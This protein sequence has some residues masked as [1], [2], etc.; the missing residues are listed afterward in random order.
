MSVNELTVQMAAVVGLAIVA[1]LLA[2]WRKTARAQA[3]PQRDLT[4]PA[5]RVPYEVV[6]AV[7]APYHRA[8][9]VRRLWSATASTG[10][11][12]IIG[13]MIATITAFGLA[14]VVTTLTDLLKK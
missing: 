11:A 6:E 12:V 3:R 8:G 14:F 2:G 4:A 9:P 1:L 5:R 13:A 7:A 10:L